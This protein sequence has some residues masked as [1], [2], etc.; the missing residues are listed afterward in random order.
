[1]AGPTTTG[2]NQGNNSTSNT[3][4]GLVALLGYEAN[5]FISY[6][7]ELLIYPQ[8]QSSSSDSSNSGCSASNQKKLYL[9]LLLKGTMPITGAVGIFSKAGVA[10][11]IYLP[12]LNSCKQN[13]NMA[14]F[15]PSISLGTNF[16][17]SEGIIADL[18]WNRLITGGSLKNIDLYAIGFSYHF[19][20]S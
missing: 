12:G 8:N 5:P 11:S 4:A 19:D 3:S 7:G 9:D 15:Y 18:S 13:S 20:V 6:E 1:M 10:T 14:N 17:L 16:S 2:S